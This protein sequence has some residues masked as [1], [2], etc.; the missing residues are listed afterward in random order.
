MG[1][2][3]GTLVFCYSASPLSADHHACCT[4][5]MGTDDGVNFRVRGVDNLWVVDINLWLKF[6]AS[7]FTT[8]TYMV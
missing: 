6:P 5:P 7:F 2:I 3:R 4:N 1:S 8:S